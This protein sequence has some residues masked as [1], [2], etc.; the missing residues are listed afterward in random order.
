MAKV[1]IRKA[2][3]GETPGYYNKTAMFLKKA[4]DGM[5][6]ESDAPTSQEE[7]LQAYY[8]Y[9]Y[10]Q[11]VNDV[12][13]ENVYNELIDKGLPKQ[14]AVRLIDSLMDRLVEEGEIDPDYKRN[15][16]EKAKAEA[17]EAKKKEETSSQEEQV[18]EE[19]E[20]PAMYEEDQEMADL[21]EGYLNDASYMQDGGEQEDEEEEEVDYDSAEGKIA[22]TDQYD[23][24]KEGSKEQITN[25]DDLIANTPGVQPGM[26]F[27]NLAEYIPDYQEI[28]WQPMDALQTSQQEVPQEMKHGGIHNKRSFVKNVMAL[29]KKQEGGEQ[30][31]AEQE[32]KDK[33]LGKGNP[34]DTITDDIKKHKNNFIDALRTKATEI[35]TGEMY[36]KLKK[37]NDPALR[38]MGMQQQEQQFQTGGMTGGEDPLYKF[39]GGGEENPDYYEADFLPEAANGITVKRNGVEYNKQDPYNYDE[40]YKDYLTDYP[41]FSTKSNPDKLDQYRQ[42]LNFY[43]GDTPKKSEK[44][45]KGSETP[46][47]IINYVPRYYTGPGTFRNT[48]LPWNPIFRGKTVMQSNPYMLGS[49]TPYTDPLKGMKPIARQV[50]KRGILGRPKQWTDIYSVDAMGRIN[51]EMLKQFTDKNTSPT[52][53]LPVNKSNTSGL[54][55]GSKAAIKLG[56]AKMARNERR[57]ARHPELLEFESKETPTK[58][59][60]FTGSLINTSGPRAEAQEIIVDEQMNPKEAYRK[61][62][63]TLPPRQEVPFERQEFKG[64]LQNMA[65]PRVDGEM[66]YGGYIPKANNGLTINNPNLPQPSPANSDLAV[67]DQAGMLTMQPQQQTWSSPSFNVPKQ[68]SQQISLPTVSSKQAGQQLMMDSRNKLKGEVA[69]Q[70]KGKLVGVDYKKQGLGI[71]GEAAVNV[72]N[73]GVRGITGMLGRKDAKNQERQMYDELTSDNLYAAQT[74]KHRGDWVDLGSQ[75]GQFRFDQMGQDRSGFSSYGKYGG[76]M[77]DGGEMDYMPEDEFPDY[78]PNYEEGDEV[79]MTE[80]DIQQFMANGGQIEYI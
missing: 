77:Q 12:D 61:S 32:S 35:K 28:E 17:E 45:K 49:R 5:Q 74:T 10:G 70:N 33:S 55:L 25:I 18:S 43:Y 13:P 68:P 3:P 2:G 50:T 76:Y 16:E 71:D 6:V 41:E 14:T 69:A 4:Q 23:Q 11:L 66:A 21:E 26:N 46:R 34:M 53:V 80:D 57:L 22:V 51:P 63:L 38:E 58:R 79:Y 19:E 73:A 72:F 20:D 44:D 56:E 75:M 78:N 40:W 54:K 7:M 64:T 8:M 59:E 30:E 65:G 39:F 15:K 67:G 48:M 37:S 27:P 36:D 47:T 52:G 1:R 9:A 60:V 31:P 62:S 29:L 24:V 42:Y